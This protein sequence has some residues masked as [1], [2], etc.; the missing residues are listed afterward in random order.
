M[1]TLY[2][3]VVALLFTLSANAQMQTGN[4][5]VF[6][7]DGAPF[8]LILNG[9]R[10]NTTAQTNVRVEML[11]NPYYKC[12]VV[13]A[14]AKIA[15]LEKTVMIE[16][17]DGMMLDVNYRIKKDKKG[18]RS[19]RF[20]SGIPAVQNMAPPA[21]CAVYHYG[22]PN[23]M[24]IGPDGTVYHETVVQTTTTNGQGYGMNVNMPG[25]GMN[26]NIPADEVVTTTTTTTTTTGGGYQNNNGY[27]NNG[28]Y[29]NSGYNNGGYNNNG[30]YGNNQGNYNNQNN[31]GYNNGGCR[32]AMNST[33]FG[34][35]LETVR[36]AKFDDTK[37]SS[38][39]EIIATN[40][41]S[42]NQI[43]SLVK[44]LTYEDNKL[45]LA[46]YAY[47]YCV[48]RNNYFKVVNAFTFES[49][50]EELNDYIKSQR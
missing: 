20:Y 24:Y 37:L 29:N 42:T 21:H 18:K 39:K 16:D 26:V 32:N 11:P 12:K 6:S 35:A 41:M 3:L 1:K 8:Y 48:E 17:A 49:S 13:F 33:D 47:G 25:F 9:E 2:S 22:E 15:P 14:N 45:E 38:A 44:L 50:K 19:L 23:D 7:E 30:G 36:T 10:Y 4:L 34:D 28:G 40:C 27:Q 43:L 31:N 46:K 5:T